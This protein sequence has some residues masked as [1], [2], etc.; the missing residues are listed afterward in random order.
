[1]VTYNSEIQPRPNEGF[2]LFFLPK[3]AA[4]TVK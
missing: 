2:S 4:V 1:M 3:A